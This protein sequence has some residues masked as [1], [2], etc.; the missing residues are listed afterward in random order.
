M[1]RKTITKAVVIAV[2]TLAAGM[3]VSS[4]T[5][6]DNPSGPAGTGNEDAVL[7]TR[8]D[9]GICY[10]QGVDVAAASDMEEPLSQSNATQIVSNFA[11][12]YSY[13]GYAYVGGYG[14]A[15]VIRYDIADDGSLDE[16]GSLAIPASTSSWPTGMAFVNDTKAYV[17]LYS[18]G[19]VMVFDP[20]TMKK[21]ALIDLTDYAVEG[22]LVSPANMIIQDDRLIVTLHQMQG[23]MAFDFRAHAVIIDTDEDTVIAHIT[24]DRGSWAASREAIPSMFVDD[25]GDVY[26][27]CSAMFGM[28]GSA[29]AGVLRIKSGATEFDPDYHWDVDATPIDGE[30]VAATEHISALYAMDYFEGTKGVG[31]I[32]NLAYMAEGEDMTTG[33]YYKPVEFD[34]EAKT[35]KVLDIPAGGGYTHGMSRYD[36]TF[37]F[38]FETASDGNGVYEY[39]PASGNIELLF[40]SQA[41]PGCIVKV[42]K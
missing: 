29:P 11:L 41:D 14:V 24:D 36:D 42:E 15:E 6:D 19:K 31:L 37:F 27:A 13:G 40:S 38:A 1:F 5:E 28:A 9:D 35:M 20:T 2:T 26:I 23:Q 8:V 33:H 32:V 34:F 18:D 12:V 22:F 3:L 4:C 16:K 30:S 17:S 7:V 21:K 39:D 25:K 10:V